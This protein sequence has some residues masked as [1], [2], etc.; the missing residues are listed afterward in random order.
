MAQTSVITAP[1]LRKIVGDER[2]PGC[3]KGIL[4]Q[5]AVAEASVFRV[6][7]GSGVPAHRHSRVYDLFVGIA[8]EVA[9][10]Y[11]GPKGRDRFALKAGAFCA[12]P[13]GVPH[14]VL[15]TGAVEAVFYL[16]HAPQEG[17]DYLPGEL[18]SEGSS[19][20]GE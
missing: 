17:Y 10:S 6:Q 14:E 19:T 16:V 2:R 18:T 15:N 13:P 9:I 20:A 12:M 8:G 5:D 7:P 11:D 4:F 3:S 1:D